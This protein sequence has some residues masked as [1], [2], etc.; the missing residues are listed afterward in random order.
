M[1]SLHLFTIPKWLPYNIPKELWV[2]IF[3]WKWRLEMKDIHKALI[4]KNRNIHTCYISPRPHAYKNILYQTA[5]RLGYNVSHNHVWFPSD[6][7]NMYTGNYWIKYDDYLSKGNPLACNQPKLVTVYNKCG[8]ELLFPYS[9]NFSPFGFDY[10]K[11][12]EHL[13]NNLN[14]D[15]SENTTYLEMKKLCQSI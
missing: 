3:C 14:I 12:Y 1:D 7:L 2:I 11:L 6:E 8:I 9:M 5:C 13:K 10:I 15:C 4:E